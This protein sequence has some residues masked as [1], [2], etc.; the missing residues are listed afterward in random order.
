MLKT[1]GRLNR[2]VDMRSRFVAEGKAADKRLRF[3]ESA[4]GYLVY[5]LR[6]RQQPEIFGRQAVKAVFE[7]QKRYQRVEIGVAARSPIPDIVP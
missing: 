3:V 2:G 4:V 1:A 7:L 5:T 6:G